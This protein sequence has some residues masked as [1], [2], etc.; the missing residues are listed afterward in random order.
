MDKNK[1]VLKDIVMLQSF[2]IFLV[3]LGHSFPE[4]N[5]PQQ[6]MWIRQ[7]IYS[8]HMPMF[9]AISGYLFIYSDG[10]KGS[11]LKFIKMK[12]IRLLIPYATL[13]S[14]AFV[15]KAMLSKLARRPVELSFSAF[16][17][18]LIYPWDNAILFFWFLPTLFLI[19]VMSYLFIK[20][21]SNR[22]SII[23]LTIIL[24]VLNLFHP[25]DR[26]Q[27]LNLSGVGFYLVYFWIGCIMAHYKKFT[28]MFFSN[29]FTFIVCS[30]GLIGCNI[31]SLDAG[32]FK[33]FV[34]II[35]IVMSFSL[36][37][38]LEKYDCKLFN[39][40]NGFSYQIY[41]LSWF[42]QTF[43]VTIL[44]NI[45]HLNYFVSLLFMLF[46]GLFLPV[47]LAK[48][49]TEFIPI[50]N[51]FIGFKYKRKFIQNNSNIAQ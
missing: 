9:M 13:S 43:F 41:L 30:L 5:M 26:I 16:V 45:M 34:S 19:F 11:Y 32:S 3:V 10:I 2:A 4:K 48:L 17:H 1:R 46:G 12:T 42:F 25:L 22:I 40:I 39:I 20:S 44:Y 29:K 7:F 33:F 38:I 21:L 51:I 31:T 36:A 8:F 14:L 47:I 49:T 28:D 23:I 27:V 35:G 15:P 37:K 50:F 24:L 18:N 6:I